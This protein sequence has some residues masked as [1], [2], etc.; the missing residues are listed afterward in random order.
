MSTHSL[1]YHNLLF[2]CLFTLCSQTVATQFSYEKA[3]DDVTISL[4]TNKTCVGF[5]SYRKIPLTSWYALHSLYV[6]PEF[7]RKGHGTALIKHA[8]A[9]L[10]N[11]KATR[12]YIQPGPFELEHKQQLNTPL[13]YKKKIDELVRLY[14]KSAFEPAHS[15]TSGIA[16]LYYFLSGIPEQS[17]YLM[18]KTLF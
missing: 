3:D 9:S 2:L 7:R 14:K 10:K 17:R 4:H 18:V 16:A 12:V 8:C 5:V 13:S 1:P 11:L 6:Y 15:I